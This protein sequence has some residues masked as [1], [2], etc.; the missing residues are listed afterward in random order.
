[1]KAGQVDGFG[2]CAD[3]EASPIARRVRMSFHTHGNGSRFKMFAYRKPNPFPNT[4]SAKIAPIAIKESRNKYSVI[5]CPRLMAVTSLT[6]VCLIMASG[7]QKVNDGCQNGMS[8]E[9]F[10]CPKYVCFA[11]F[12]W[13]SLEFIVGR[14]ILALYW[15]KARS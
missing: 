10:R 9:R 11:F 5:V 7:F 15:T 1:M 8:G 12:T 3:A 13:V 2:R 14:S 6:F 4:V